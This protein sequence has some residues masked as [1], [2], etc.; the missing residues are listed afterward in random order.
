MIS[1]VFVCTGNLCRSPMAEGILR[2]RWLKRGRGD[3]TVSS[4]GIHGLD[5]QPASQHAREVCAEHGIDISPHRSR[6]LVYEELEGAHLVL[7]MEPV[8]KE[9]VGLFFPRFKDKVFLLGAWPGKET[10]KSTISDPMGQSIRMYRRTFE[11]IAEHIDRII[12][13]I[14]EFYG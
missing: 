7:A 1:V 14:E 3:L 9:F 13:S 10:R 8:Q 11:T 4:M 6:Q 12:P 5:S 2:D